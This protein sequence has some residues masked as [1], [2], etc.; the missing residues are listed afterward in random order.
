MIHSLSSLPLK[1]F[2][3]LLTSPRLSVLQF[4]FYLSSLILFSS[5]VPFVLPLY[6]LSIFS[7]LFCCFPYLSPFLFSLPA[8]FSASYLSLC[9]TRYSLNSFVM[10]TRSYSSFRNLFAASYFSLYSAE[11]FFLS[12]LCSLVMSSRP[13]VHSH[14]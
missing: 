5:H 10:L 8:F 2:L 9:S 4:L 3:Y 7:V 11:V 1:P 12:L 14:F 13:T 6:C